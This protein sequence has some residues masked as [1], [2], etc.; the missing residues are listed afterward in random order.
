MADDGMGFVAQCLAQV[1]QSRDLVHLVLIYTGSKCLLPLEER[2]QIFYQ[3]LLQTCFPVEMTNVALG[4]TI[5]IRTLS[6]TYYVYTWGE[7]RGDLFI[8]IG[9]RKVYERGTW[10]RIPRVQRQS[11]LYR[12]DFNVSEEEEIESKLY[13]ANEWPNLEHVSSLDFVLRLLSRSK[14]NTEG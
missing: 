11:S 10:I 9:H 6:R 2:V 1:L 5:K 8:E 3:A 14:K 12:D 4:Q 7:K 13:I